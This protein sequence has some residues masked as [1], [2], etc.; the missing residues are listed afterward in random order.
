VFRTTII[1]SC[2]TSSFFWRLSSL[3]AERRG[4]KKEEDKPLGKSFHSQIYPLHVMMC[5]MYIFCPFFPQLHDELAALGELENTYVL[6]TSDHG[7]HLGQF[8]L[9]KGKSFPF[10]VDIR[11]PFLVRGPSMTAGEVRREPVLNIDLA[12]TILVRRYRTLFPP[13]YFFYLFSFHLSFIDVQDMAGV[14]QPGHM[15]GRSILEAVQPR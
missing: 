10:D 12:P 8:G 6:Y 15:D 7:Y 9:V 13:R 4:K 2:S 14:D 1:S 5:S 11:V 3:E